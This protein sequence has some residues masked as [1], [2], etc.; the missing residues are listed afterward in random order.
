LIFVKYRV[1]LYQ[2]TNTLKL[3]YIMIRK[4]SMSI[5]PSEISDLVY[6]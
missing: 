3:A 1:G 2:L 6:F 5:E 4:V